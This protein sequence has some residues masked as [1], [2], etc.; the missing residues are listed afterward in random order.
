MSASYQDLVSWFNRSVGFQSGIF[1]LSLFFLSCSSNDNE[2]KRQL[3]STEGS[4]AE[5]VLWPSHWPWEMNPGLSS[6]QPSYSIPQIHFAKFSFLQSCN[7]GHP[8]TS[9]LLV[10]GRLLALSLEHTRSQ[11]LIEVFKKRSFS[12]N[13]LN[14][15]I[16]NLDPLKTHMCTH[17]YRFCSTIRHEFS[18]QNSILYI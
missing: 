17:I 6:T 16:V 9:K 5:L 18:T 14:F 2:V 7:C 10:P 8:S 4:N 1:L 15:I 3:I 11:I 13:Y 12:N